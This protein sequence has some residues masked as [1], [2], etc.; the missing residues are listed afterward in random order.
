MRDIVIQTFLLIF[1]I[2]GLSYTQKVQA[3]DSTKT[4]KKWYTPDYIKLQFA[5]NI[6]FVSFGTGYSWWKEKAQSD[7]IYGYVPEYHG[8][9][10]IHTFTQ[11]NSFRLINF[12][13]RDYEFSMFSGFSVSFE[14][15]QNSFVQVPNKYPSGYYSPNFVYACIF[16]GTKLKFDIREK[17]YFDFIE[18]YFEINTLGDYIFYNLIAGEEKSS[19]I[20]SLALGFSFFFPD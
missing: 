13:K 7:I 18:S 6:G 1:F 15:G 19:K 10:R 16:L 8:N 5:G 12:N 4:K 11:K 14:P 17:Y 3:F 9:A 2:Q 20:F